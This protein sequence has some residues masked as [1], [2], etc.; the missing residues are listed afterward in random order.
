MD[1]N[2]IRV[3]IV[4]LGR[5]GWG[6]HTRELDPRQD[7]FRIVAGCDVDP[8]RCQRMAERYGC[9][10]YPD[11]AGL[12]ADPDVELVDIASRTPEHVPHA[13][14]ALKANKLVFLEKPIAASY[15]E[16]KKLK[17]AAARSKGRLFIRH[18]RRF[19][20]AFQHI[21][22]LLASGILGNVY[23]IKLRRLGYQRRDDWQT[24]KS[25]AGGQLLN[26]GPHIV[27][28]A[29][30]F[31]DAPVARMW[32]D[33][34]KVAAVGDAEDHVHIVLK[35]EDGRTVDLEISGG[36]AL[37]VPVYVIFGSKGALTCDEKE[38]RLRYLDPT[39]QLPPRTPDP[40]SP[41][42]E[43]GFGS[44]DVLKWVEQTIR[45][46]PAAK[47]I[48]ECIWDALYAAI[49]EGAEFPITLDQALEV[50]RVISA[51]KKGTEFEVK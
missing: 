30:R 12:I 26:W 25:C 35:G 34:R 24:L 7:K 47:C 39:V 5:A 32:S 14:A 13:L 8:A 45:V 10:T 16:A 19:E 42:M 31:L 1:L 43:G 4:G 38:I 9:K 36:V 23:D 37:A 46:A 33:L 21:R 40:A 6:M 3:G 22:E 2:P 51:A 20:A 49:R 50:M 28:H 17:P 44:P 18:N 11:I 15:T 48:P 27:D 29:L 41:P